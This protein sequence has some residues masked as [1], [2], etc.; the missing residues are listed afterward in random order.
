MNNTIA[1][2]NKIL[3]ISTPAYILETNGQLSFSTKQD[4]LLSS[5]ERKIAFLPGIGLETLG[6]ST[7]KQR[8]GLTYPYIAGAMANGISS[9][10]MVKT[11]ADNGMVGFLGAGGLSLEK[12][13]E[14]IL[15]LKQDLKEKPFGFNLIHSL[16]DPDHE[17]ATVELYL[18]HKI[19]LISAAAFMRMTL[20][21]VYYRVK[22]LFRDKAQKVIAPNRIIAKV[23]RIEIARQFFAPPPEK[24]VAQLLNA[25]LI[26]REEAELSHEIPMAQDLTA[27]ADSGG[28]TDN[29]PALTLLPT[30]IG[31]KNEFMEIYHYTAPLCVGMAGGIS[32]P[33]SAAAAFGMGAAYILTGSINQSCVEANVCED[34]KRLLS[35]A[36]QADV[37]MAPAADMFEI[38]ARV[39]VLK[40]GTLFPVRAEK[41]YQLYK[42][43]GCFEEINEHAR[44]E[45]EEKFLLTG[46]EDAWQS[47]RQFFE[48]QGNPKEIQRAQTDPKHKMALVFRSYLGQSSRWAINGNPQRKMDYQIWCGPSIGAFNQWV[49]GSFLEGPENRKTAEV[50]LNLLFGACLCTRTSF[51]KAQGI[52]LPPELTAFKPLPKQ[53]LFSLI[54][55][56]F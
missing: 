41:L 11:M 55:K 14:N 9:A 35:Q 28:H 26:T 37:A 27:E 24:L 22:G 46:F 53:A 40:R 18:K 43:H 51:L 5:P 16:G 15:E 17:M 23:S 45:I 21:L 47:T 50:A 20:P 52:E 6:D 4:P 7:F 49:K 10:Q 31:L 1:L 36:E 25:G 19:R 33:E 3:Q 34:V 44:K 38:G 8:H 13:E 32:T 48:T 2:R 54:S 30:M 29:R 12:I 56:D 39:Q 42:T